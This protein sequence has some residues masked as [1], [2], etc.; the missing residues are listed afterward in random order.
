MVCLFD[1]HLP[2][3]CAQVA[4]EEVEGAE[5]AEPRVPTAVVKLDDQQLVE[6]LLSSIQGG[7][8]LAARASSCSF[9]WLHPISPICATRTLHTPRRRISRLP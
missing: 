6:K 2:L 4:T 8:R 7:L 9:T 1:A 5:E 3:S